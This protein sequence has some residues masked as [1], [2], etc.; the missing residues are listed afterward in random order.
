MQIEKKNRKKM[1]A[2]DKRIELVKLPSEGR[3]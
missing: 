3:S 1:K 2:F